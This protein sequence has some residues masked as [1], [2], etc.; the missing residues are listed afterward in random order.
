ML[1]SYG[2][3]SQHLSDALA[4]LA[5]RLCTDY[6]DPAILG[7]LLANRLIPL[8]KSPGTRPVG[9]GEVPRRIMGKSITGVLKGDIM[10]AAGSTQL[11][12]GQESGIEAAI[13]AM[14]RLFKADDTD[15]IL[16]VDAD[17]AFNRLNRAVALHNIRF[18]CPQLS[19]A[20]INI[21]LR[22]LVCSLS[23]A[24][25][26]PLLRAQLK[27]AL[28]RWLCMPSVSFH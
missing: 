17:N 4:L 19:I 3:H 12:A 18:I 6:M 8:D 5:R 7:P 9:I 22:Q 24:W 27:A 10:Q 1:F 21:H 11:C 26:S 2:D 25:S 15:A 28:L 13:H 16:L 14:I 23:A 20:L